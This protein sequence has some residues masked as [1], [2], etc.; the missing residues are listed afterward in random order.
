MNALMAGLLACGCVSL[1]D[2]PL[3]PPAS[4]YINAAV[5]CRQSSNATGCE[6]AR[7]SW[8]GDFNDA[9]AGKNEAQTTI[10]TCFSTGCDGAI[11]PDPMLGCAWRKVAMRAAHGQADARDAAGLKQYCS[12]PYLD[13]AGQHAA[14]EE[15]L[16]LQQML[17]AK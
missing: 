1:I 3:W 11:R 9:I 2:A 6:S 16:A 8:T 7:K 12:Q 13:V 10:A 17:S 14:D 5:D 15:A 4:D